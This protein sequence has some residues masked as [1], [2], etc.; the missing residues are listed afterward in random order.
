MLQSIPTPPSASP[1]VHR[2]AGLLHFARISSGLC[3]RIIAL[4]ILWYPAIV[5][6]AH[7]NWKLWSLE[8]YR[9][10]IRWKD[11]VRRV[12]KWRRPRLRLQKRL[13]KRKFPSIVHCF[14][15]LLLH[16]FRDCEL[17]PSKKFSNRDAERRRN[18]GLKHWICKLR[19]VLE[20]GNWGFF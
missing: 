4:R 3:A 9:R 5:A 11:I 17:P 12:W 19:V 2:R 10:I 8:R 18:F 6:L 13:M 14:C 20:H 1:A 7:W 15:F 16:L